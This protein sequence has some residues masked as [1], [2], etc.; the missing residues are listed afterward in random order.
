MKS[1]HETNSTEN[2]T[3]QLKE[4]E[5]KYNVLKE[6][7]ERL[8]QALKK[9][10]SNNKHKEYA[11]E[12]QNEELKL[13]Y[14]K[15]KSENIKLQD[16]LDTQNKLW[17]MWIQK[18]EDNPTQVITAETKKTGNDKLNN[19]EILLIEE[20]EIN[21]NVEDEETET[22]FQNYLKSL[23]ESGFRRTSPAEQAQTNRKRTLKCI[24][25]NFLAKDSNELKEH[26]KQKHPADKNKERREMKGQK[27][28]FCH[29]W[30]NYG[31]CSFESRNG[32][33]CKFEHRIAPR[34][35]FDGKCDRKFCMFV[36]KT[37]NMSFLL[38][39]QPNFRHQGVQRE[40]NQVFNQNQLGGP[41]VWGNQRRY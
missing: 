39:A 25:C 26:L 21:D 17:K 36:H 24:T 12:I 16:N 7:Y 9:A 18:F 41:R 13:G 38:S 19:D 22:I 4:L 10:E 3:K 14:E 34:C 11:L 33:P 6:N 32:R 30:N 35:K 1:N 23:K 2:S 15:V 29:Y 37:Q 27:T 20:D 8:V 28:Q 31:S 5:E 40:F